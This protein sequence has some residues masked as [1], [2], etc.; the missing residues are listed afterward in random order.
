M[1]IVVPSAVIVGMYVTAFNHANF[2]YNM[3]QL[4]NQSIRL[5]MVGAI[6]EDAHRYA[7]RKDFAP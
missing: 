4:N 1:A 2:M 3:V 7:I 5:D 6:S